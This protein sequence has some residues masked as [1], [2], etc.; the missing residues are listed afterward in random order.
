M[1][2]SLTTSSPPLPWRKGEA[3]TMVF[4][5]VIEAAGRDAFEDEAGESFRER[6]RERECVCVCVC[7]SLSA[8]AATRERLI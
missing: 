3:A 1:E 8:S 5:V 7:M 6:E 4:T 2:G